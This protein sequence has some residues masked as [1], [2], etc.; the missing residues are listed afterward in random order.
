MISIEEFEKI[1]IRVGKIISCEL[2][3]KA[4]KP[5]YKLKIDF[6]ELG[7]KTSSAQLT[8]LYNEDDLVGRQIIAVTNFF[9]KQIADVI[10]EVLVLGINSKQGIVLLKPSVLVNNGDKIF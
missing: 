5:A 6:G 2:N 8:D 4:K 7:V 9:P 1:D 10:S 3:Q